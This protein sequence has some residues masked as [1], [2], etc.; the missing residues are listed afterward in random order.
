MSAA[1]MVIFVTNGDAKDATRLPEHL[2]GGFR[3]LIAC[4]VEVLNA[5]V[6]CA[7]GI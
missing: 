6:G 5:A 3:Y 2:Y 1:E 4:G 7:L